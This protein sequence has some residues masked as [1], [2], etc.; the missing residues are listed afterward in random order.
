MTTTTR[1]AE[2]GPTLLSPLRDFLRTEASSGV[3]LVAATLVALLWANS[4]WSD[5]Y[6]SFWQRT[7][8]V[9]VGGWQLELT[10]QYWV[11]DALMAIFFFVV[12]LE[13][14]RELANGHL[15][16]R[17]TAMLPV[18]GALGGML[19][20]ALIYLAIAGSTAPRG[21]AVPVA[22]DI[23]LAVGVVTLAGTAVPSGLRAF[24]LGLAIV[25][26]IGAILIIALVYSSGVKPA[27]L[28]VSVGAVLLAVLLRRLGVR[29]TLPF[30]VIAVVAWY[31]LYK[32]GI[33]PTLAG[34]AMGL[35]AP[36]EPHTSSEMIDIEEFTDVSTVEAA[37]TSTALA[38]SSVSEV[39]WLQHML[40]PWTSFVIVPIFAIAN[41][42]VE[43]SADGLRDLF[44]SALGWGIAL[45]LLVGKPLG[46]WLSTRLAVRIGV[47]EMPASHRPRPF[48]GV[49]MAAGIGFTVA[50][51]V[52]ELAFTD[53][54]QRDQA[55]LA[56]LLASVMA[57]AL[58]LPTLRSA[59]RQRATV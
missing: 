26:D 44:S 29:G 17:R 7:A 20:P 39:E 52:A 2:R 23:A 59:G 35:L 53:P 50:L 56:V 51:F 25:D 54:V 10:L 31:Y 14:K 18:A 19:V 32:A 42:G 58:A 40:H 1:R 49:G 46:I 8:A 4:P 48:L 9:S 34:V 13:I 38:R 24:L 27:Q 37:R 43:V 5:S 45:G 28:A 11:N 30:L 33:H 36:T 47:A 57:G 21:W 55:K 6:E 12:G 3:L 16:T 41:A 22:T 15:S